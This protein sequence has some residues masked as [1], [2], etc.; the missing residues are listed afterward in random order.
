M[1]SIFIYIIVLLYIMV[2]NKKIAYIVLLV[3]I[4][5]VFVY[6]NRLSIF[7]LYEPAFF[8]KKG[9]S[10]PQ[11]NERDAYN[12]NKD[13]T[14]KINSISSDRNLENIDTKIN[15]CQK[16]IDEINAVLPRKIE[17]I[18]IGRVSQTENLEDVNID[19]NTQTQMTLDPITNQNTPSSIWTIN[20]ILPR[21]KQGPSGIQG[22]KGESGMIGDT[23][24]PGKQGQQGP[25]GKD[26]DKC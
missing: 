21:G 13:T 1:R 11:V 24:K 17:D 8:A 19:I 22:Q 9:P 14:G 20:A 5:I 18:Q 23:G 6:V 25:W 26:C 7:P 4:L 15:N 12:D 2:S 3:V 16:L 10:A